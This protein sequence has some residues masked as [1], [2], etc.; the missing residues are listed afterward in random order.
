MKFQNEDT[1]EG[2]ND[3]DFDEFE[4]ADEENDERDETNTYDNN[5]DSSSNDDV[6]DEDEE[7]DNQ[8]SIKTIKTDFHGIRVTDKIKPHIERTYFSVTIN[9]ETKFLHKQSACWLLSSEKS[10]LS[11]DRLLRIQHNNNKK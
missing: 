6:T 2:L 3:M 11:S 9:D 10:K 7:N 1:N 8:N 4:L 5:D